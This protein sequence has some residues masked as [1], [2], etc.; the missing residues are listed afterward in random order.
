MQQPFLNLS[1]A[2][3][4]VETVLLEGCAED[5]GVGFCALQGWVV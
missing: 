3:H 1:S 4:H 2:S 5:D